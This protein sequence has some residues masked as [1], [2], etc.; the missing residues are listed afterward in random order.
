M[1]EIELGK[2][3]VH[4]LDSVLRIFDLHKQIGPKSPESGG[5]L[6]GQVNDNNIYI[7]KA[8]TP[9]VRDKSSRTF[10][11][12]DKVVAQSIID[13]EFFN[14]NR[15]TI[16]LGEW[17]THPE[18]TPKPSSTDNKMIKAQFSK[19]ELNEPFLVQIIRGTQALYLGL[20]SKY[21]F[22]GR[23]VTNNEIILD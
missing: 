23:V 3:R 12:R 21:K 20:I 4:I 5:V 22:E 7:M 19:N 11:V 16:Y 14:S 13:Y 10:F 9:S 18:E 15:K 2:Y 6:L 1:I 17:H 8:S